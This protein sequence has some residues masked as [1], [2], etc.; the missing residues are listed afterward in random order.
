MLGGVTAETYLLL[1]ACSLLLAYLS[2]RY[3]EQ[4]F[5]IRKNYTRKQIFLGSFTGSVLLISI[6]LMGYYNVGTSGRVP[7]E[8][9]KIM[10]W[11]KDRNPRMSECFLGLSEQLI[12][13][14]DACVY[15][16]EFKVKTAIWGDSHATA[17]ANGLAE[18]IYPSKQ[19]L[20]EFSFAGCSPSLNIRRSD[21]NSDCAEFNRNTFK[22]I[23]EHEEIETVVLLSRWTLYFEGAGFDNQEG[24]VESQP[25]LTFALPADKGI[26]FIPSPER[27]DT[28]GNLYRETIEKLLH[29][30]KKVVLVYPIPEV[31]WNVPRELARYALL[32]I[33]NDRSLSTSF[34]VFGERNEKARVQLDRIGD[35][36]NLLRIYPEYVFCNTFVEGRCIS[37]LES[38]PL[39]F[40][41]DHL[42]NIGAEMLS[43]DIIHQMEVRGW[44]N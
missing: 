9:L 6:G 27:V 35:H 25:A 4:P 36:P 32:N 20:K 34:E 22:Y 37:Q 14:E 11:E 43:R 12:A 13:P 8:V 16:A 19:G 39:Y 17:L 40:D 15:N 18:A 7:D 42:N 28:V 30:G 29:A 5:R 31:G 23:V 24:G 44:L 21:I 10:A 1:G 2:W 33:Q 41:D 26:D 3:V 38:K